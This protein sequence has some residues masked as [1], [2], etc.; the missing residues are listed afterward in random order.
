L[1][2]NIPKDTMVRTYQCFNYIVFWGCAVYRMTFQHPVA[3][4]DLLIR[5]VSF[6]GA[7]S[8][9]R[10]LLMCYIVMYYTCFF[11]MFRLYKARHQVDYIH[12]CC[13]VLFSVLCSKCRWNIIKITSELLM[14]LVETNWNSTSLIIYILSCQYSVFSWILVWILSVSTVPCFDTDGLYCLWGLLMVS[15]K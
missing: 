14:N 11:Y 7:T 4:L 13:I 8:W 1:K 6:G 12:S 2:F 10:W 3:L 15:M 9:V 5:R